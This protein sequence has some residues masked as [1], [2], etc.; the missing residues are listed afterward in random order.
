MDN[1]DAEVVDREEDAG[2]GRNLSLGLGDLE[3]NELIA[4]I[5]EEEVVAVFSG[6]IKTETEVGETEKVK[7]Q[8][9]T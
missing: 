2:R 7:V 8:G 9:A 6:V 1:K 5:K 3:W 4:G